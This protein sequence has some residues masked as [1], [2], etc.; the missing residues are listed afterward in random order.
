MRERH[1]VTFY[2]QGTMSAGKI[3]GGRD[4]M[5]MVY[6]LIHLCCAGAAADGGH[7][8]PT[9]SRGSFDIGHGGSTYITITGK[10]YKSELSPDPARVSHVLNVY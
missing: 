3:H 7:L 6:L 10:H 5:M 8:F 2:L 9:L 1:W 4:G